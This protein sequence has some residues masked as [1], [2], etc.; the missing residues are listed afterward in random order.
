MRK[1]AWPTAVC[2]LSIQASA[3]GI[4]SGKVIQIRVDR[5]GTGRVFFEQPVVS[6][7]PGCVHP[8]YTSA[9]AFDVN[10]SGGKAIM[11]VALNAKSTGATVRGLWSGRV[12]HLRR[13]R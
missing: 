12:R 8:A 7:P 5:D 9:L 10:L 11:A 13:P 4:V 6:S 1:I 3:A 2:V